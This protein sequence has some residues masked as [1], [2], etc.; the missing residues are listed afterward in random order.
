[1]AETNGAEEEETIET[2]F[3]FVPPTTT[4]SRH[5][6]HQRSSPSTNKHF[7]K[8]APLT[9]N[10]PT[11]WDP[12]NPTILSE[13][14]WPGPLFN[15]TPADQQTWKG[16]LIPQP[17]ERY[18]PL[19][20]TQLEW[21]RTSQQYFRPLFIQD[22][23]SARVV[24]KLDEIAKGDPK[25]F[26][27]TEAWNEPG[28][29]GRPSLA[30]TQLALPVGASPNCPVAVKRWRKEFT[31][32]KALK[33]LSHNNNAIKIPRSKYMQQREV[34]RPRAP[35]HRTDEEKERLIEFWADALTHNLSEESN[36]DSAHQLLFLSIFPVYKPDDF[37]K[38]KGRM[39][40]NGKEANQVVRD[41]LSH[42]QDRGGAHRLR[43]SAS[44]LDLMVGG[45]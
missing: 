42:Y 14:K 9:E 24:E 34:G 41:V 20:P 15:P 31:H 38:K 12:D 30:E 16:E 21:L 17:G 18:E 43:H 45:T 37:L 13:I 22:P 8:P 10:N 28:D 39:C 3:P 32:K 19:Q 11:K 36:P 26:I 29:G 35:P 4:P 25:G 5:K 33:L 1:M 7:R 27:A 6:H 23:E 44:H 2:V 40:M